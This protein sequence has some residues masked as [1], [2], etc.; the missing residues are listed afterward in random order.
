MARAKK[1]PVPQKGGGVAMMD[2][3]GFTRY[4]ADNP[5]AARNHAA[6]RAVLS[7]LP[8]L[9]WRGDSAIPPG[10]PPHDILEAFRE[11]TD[12][13]LEL[14][15]TAFLFYLSTLL[16]SKGVKIKIK[17]AKGGLTVTP[18]V[19]LVSLAPSGS[20]KSYALNIV[21]HGAPLAATITGIAS[22]AKFIAEM[23]DNE[24]AGMVNA[25]L[26]DEFGQTLK[27][28]ETIGS[29][30]FDA[31]GYLLKSYD[32][33]KLER[34]TKAE[35]VTVL[36]SRLSFYGLNVDKTFIDGCISAES[37]LDGF[38]QRF[39]YSIAECDPERPQYNY[40]LY[41]TD[42][43][44]RTAESAW[45]RVLST[46]IHAEYTYAPETLEAYN[47]EFRQL[48]KL[49]YDGGQV[50]ASFFRRLMQATHKLA[51]FM[52]IILGGESPEISKTAMLYAI[53]QTRLNILDAAKLIAMKAP[54]QTAM[55]SA[56]DELAE[57]LAAKGER[58]TPRSIRA[59][60]R[61]AREDQQ[62]AEDLAQAHQNSRSAAD[63]AASA[64]RPTRAA[65]AKP[66]DDIEEI[67]ATPREEVAKPIRAQAARPIR[68]KVAKPPALDI[69][70]L[71]RDHRDENGATVYTG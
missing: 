67:E 64:R 9:A 37:M 48:G 58:L 62:L 42:S 29:P 54:K 11:H 12:I 5:E 8:K 3:S 17:T 51:L 32:G 21:G 45:A 14:P 65:R 19:W 1:I 22:G 57:R 35:T 40:P 25:M 33:G 34:K 41:D 36:D 69:N 4:L 53:R 60:I 30:L 6:A 55:L 61:A 26:D 68:A 20:G 16:L 59:G 46:P 31:K 50:N 15:W 66:A 56:V 10:S 24:T 44:K 7:S 2:N 27:S 70:D 49:I 28:L 13:P 38:A 39:M 47:S 63:T 52:H 71:I 18:E 23:S 43:L